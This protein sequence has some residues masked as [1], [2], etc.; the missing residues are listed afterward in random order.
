M[1][2]V[3]ICI[4]T[5]NHG[6]GLRRLLSSIQSLETNHRISIVV[7]D[8]A[9][10]P[11]VRDGGIGIGI[12]KRLI[13]DGYRWPIIAFGL[14]GRDPARIRNALA[15]RAFD[16]GAPIFLVFLDD[17]AS[18]QTDWLDQLVT[19]QRRTDA[20]F[21]GG[22]ILPEF[23]PDTPEWVARTGLFGRSGPADEE[24]CEFGSLD[25]VLIRSSIFSKWRRPWF[26]LDQMAP[27]LADARFLS[28]ARESGGYGVW[29]E[30][31]AMSVMIAEEQT[32]PEWMRDAF[33]E[34]AR[35]EASARLAESEDTTEIGH[36]RVVIDAARTIAAGCLEFVL[37]GMNRAARFRALAGMTAE[38]ARFSVLWR[39][40][41]TPRH[42]NTLSPHET[43]R[44]SPPI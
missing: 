14:T 36:L 11:D 3:T 40:I 23:E 38:I 26:S 24:I 28:R 39:G 22:P 9:L 12:C 37:A 43:Q 21:V 31:A 15:S 30:R 13:D 35:A 34:W 20:D 42:A 6:Y 44:S 16:T 2:D 27:E 4:E 17:T 1:T 18:L 10:N 25:G 8:T 32:K 29:A 5:H 19:T 33:K 41:G 7:A